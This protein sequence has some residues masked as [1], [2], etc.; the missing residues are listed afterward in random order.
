M[1]KKNKGELVHVTGMAILGHMAIQSQIHFNLHILKQDT[2]AN[3]M[4][5][6]Q[7]TDHI[8]SLNAQ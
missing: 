1:Q 8:R 2:L 5:V 3:Y 6:W 7:C 4:F